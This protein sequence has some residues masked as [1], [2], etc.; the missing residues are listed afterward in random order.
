VS[1]LQAYAVAT[2]GFLAGALASN[3]VKDL[4]LRGF[5]RAVLFAAAGEFPALLGLVG[6]FLAIRGLY[7]H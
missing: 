5:Q 2:L 4:S 7:P 6:S 3:R 1:S